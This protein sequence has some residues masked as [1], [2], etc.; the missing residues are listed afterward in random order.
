MPIAVNVTNLTERGAKYLRHMSN[1][2]A[3]GLIPS[4]AITVLGIMDRNKKPNEKR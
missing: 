4:L 3:D 1:G 2:Y